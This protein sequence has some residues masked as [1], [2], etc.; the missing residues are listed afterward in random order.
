MYRI[1]KL[2]LLEL[3]F[4][5]GE[6]EGLLVRTLR[7]LLVALVYDLFYFVE[8]LL[9]IDLLDRYLVVLL[10]SYLE[11]FKVILINFLLI[12]VTLRLF[13]IE[14]LISVYLRIQIVLD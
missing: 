6:K 3:I 12:K 10:R 4:L 1:H 9:L 7:T 14:E 8:S 5:R 13:N 11:T 2:L